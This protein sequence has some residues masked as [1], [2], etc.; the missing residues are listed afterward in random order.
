[1]EPDLELLELYEWFMNILFLFGKLKQIY[2]YPK[3]V[4]LFFIS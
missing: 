2:F 3:T 4:F 1:M